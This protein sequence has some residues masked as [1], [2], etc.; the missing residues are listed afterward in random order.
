MNNSK[1]LDSCIQILKGMRGDQSNELESE[2]QRALAGEIRK[3]KKL[4][5]QPKMRHDD[6]YRV[7]SEVAETVSKICTD[8]RP[9]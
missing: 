8:F 1:Y 5:K 4:K 6:V 3:L 9:K 2:Q 7:V